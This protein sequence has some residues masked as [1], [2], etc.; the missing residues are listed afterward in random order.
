MI[1]TS[2][3]IPVYNN[4]Y[5]TKKALASVLQDPDEEFQLTIWD[6]ASEDG[7]R[8]FL[9]TL[10]D[11]RIVD[12]VLSDTNVDSLPARPRMSAFVIVCAT[13]LIR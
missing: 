3:I 2:I 5:Y 9:K 11:R 13:N 10:D 6:N 4:A 8:E 7:T 1:Q 12:V